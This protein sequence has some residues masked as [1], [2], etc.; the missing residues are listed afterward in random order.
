M[1]LGCV[2][3][4]WMGCVMDKAGAGWVQTVECLEGLA[5]ELGLPFPSAR[6]H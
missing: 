2:M 6:K 5:K 3:V 4:Q 1:T